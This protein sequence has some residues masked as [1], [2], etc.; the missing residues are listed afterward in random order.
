MRIELGNDIGLSEEMKEQFH[1]LRL[2]GKAS[3]GCH[4]C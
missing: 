1:D 3:K 4:G 2:C